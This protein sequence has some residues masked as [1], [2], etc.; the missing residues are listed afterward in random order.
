MADD[1]GLAGF[2]ILHTD[3]LALAESRLGNVERLS[4]QLESSIEAFRNLL[5]KKPRNDQSRQKL[6]TGTEA[7]FL[8]GGAWRILFCSSRRHS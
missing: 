3:L 4:A 2:Q 1:I 5:A 6:M 7:P 8:E